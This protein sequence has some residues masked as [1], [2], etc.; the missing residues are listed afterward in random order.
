MAFQGLLRAQPHGL[1]LLGFIGHGFLPGRHTRHQ[2]WHGKALGQVAVSRP[3]GQLVHGVG[4]Q[5]QATRA[6]LRQQGAAAVKGGNVV[7]VGPAAIGMARQQHAQL[8]KTLADGGQ[9]VGQRLAALRR[10]VR[11]G[12]MGLG[13]GVLRLNASAGEHVGARHEAGFVG[14]ARHQHFKLTVGVIAQQ[15]NRGRQQR[16]DG[17][18]RRVQELVGA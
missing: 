17:G 8:F 9:C 3:V 5:L 7:V 2:K 10:A 11:G 12:G 14:A 1:E 4:G 6:A 16:G 13:R 15:Q 18:A